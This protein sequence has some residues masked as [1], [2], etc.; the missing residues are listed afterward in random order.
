MGDIDLES[1]EFGDPKNF[2]PKVPATLADVD[3]SCFFCSGVMVAGPELF[4]V[5]GDNTL[6]LNDVALNDELGSA[7]VNPNDF[8]WY[9]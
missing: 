4:A 6:E 1:S 3:D 8:L 2:K 7:A 5:G 9:S